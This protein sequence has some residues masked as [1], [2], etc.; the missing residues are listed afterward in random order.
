[1]QPPRSTGESG[2]VSRTVRSDDSYCIRSL[3]SA[4]RIGQFAVSVCACKP[5][6]DGRAVAFA[7]VSSTNSLNT[8]YTTVNEFKPTLTNRANGFGS[9]LNAVMVKGGI[10]GADRWVEPMTMI[11]DYRLQCLGA[12]VSRRSSSGSYQT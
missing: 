3:V 1:M 11:T 8:A 12:L 7:A 2:G 9:H 6:G 5:R 4:Q 10:G